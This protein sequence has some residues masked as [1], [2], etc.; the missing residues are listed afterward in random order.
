M[1][2]TIDKSTLQSNERADLPRCQTCRAYVNPYF[3]FFNNFETFKCNLCNK[4]QPTPGYYA[5]IR[6]Q[7]QNDGIEDQQHPEQ[8]NGTYE[9]VANDDYTARPPKNPTYYF[10]IDISKSSYTNNVPFYAISA[11]KEAI[12]SQRFNGGAN[13]GLALF[14]TMLHVVEFSDQPRLFSF[15]PN[16]EQPYKLPSVKL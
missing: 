9:L 4:S 2:S 16:I 15:V 3:E 6:R 8:L 13:I 14:D 5:N 11:L 10:V 7:A 12:E 1:L